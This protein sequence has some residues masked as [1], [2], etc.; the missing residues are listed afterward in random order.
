MGGWGYWSPTGGQLGITDLTMSSFAPINYRLPWNFANRPGGISSAATFDA[1]IES[2]KRL[3]AFGSQHVGGAHFALT[4]G[5]TR[6]INENIDA[7]TLRGLS[8]R[9]GGEVFGEF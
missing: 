9:V 1:S 5:S 6:F 2:I 7:S 8:T 3:C 4:D